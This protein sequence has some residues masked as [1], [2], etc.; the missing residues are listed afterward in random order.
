[1]PQRIIEQAQLTEQRSLLVR[2][3]P[4][5]RFLRGFFQNVEVPRD[6][7]QEQGRQQ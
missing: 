4:N 2:T 5:A 1:M 3:Q 7:D 6:H